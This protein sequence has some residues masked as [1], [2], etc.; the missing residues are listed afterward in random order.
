MAARY[1][2]EVF[3]RGIQGTVVLRVTVEP[4]GA[5][6]NIEVIRSGS[7]CIRDRRRRRGGRAWLDLEP[8]RQG[9]E[10]VRLA[11]TVSVRFATAQAPGTAPAA[12]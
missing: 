1:P 12:R 6:S 4:D 8:G 11:T 9:D 3:A 5:V 2:A 10:R 7:S